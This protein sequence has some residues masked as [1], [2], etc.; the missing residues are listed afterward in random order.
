MSYII[1]QDFKKII[2]NDNLLQIIGSDLSIISG[3]EAIAQAEV[4]SYLVQKYL[5]TQEFTDT[6]IYS[7][8]ASYL[9][10]N[11]VYLDALA[12]AQTT[13]LQGAL[14][15]QLGN[16]YICTNNITVPEAFNLANWSLLGVQY[17]I[18]YVPYPYPTFNNYG[19]YSPGNKV[20]WLNKVY[21][22]IKG[23]TLLNHEYQLQA[24][25]NQAILNVFPDDV[26]AGLQTWGVGVPY[27]IAP[28]SLLTAFTKG[29]NRNPQLVMYCCDIALYHVH[30]RIAPRNIP[31]LRMHRY[32]AAIKWCKM[33]GVGD[34][35]ADL[36]LIQPKSGGR[37]RFGGNVRNQN[38]Y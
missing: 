8:T 30:S 20:F 27:A 17:S 18:F 26:F 38:T 6:Q 23:T 16:V 13:F 12:Y 11:R 34:I 4:I 25:S 31:E 24:N 10:T 21:T 15:L 19:F 1:Y 29:D 5:T 33:A 2:Q 14:T 7:V 32:D 36:P 35:T 28:N 3:V 22:C 9:A 37:I